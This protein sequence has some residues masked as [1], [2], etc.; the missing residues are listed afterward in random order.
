MNVSVTSVTRPSTIAPTR[1]RINVNDARTFTLH[2][3]K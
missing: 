3:G 1:G 2:M